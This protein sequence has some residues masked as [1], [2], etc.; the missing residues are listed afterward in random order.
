MLGVKQS[1]IDKAN[2]V[3]LKRLGEGAFQT[4]SKIIGAVVD[5][6]DDTD[7][8]HRKKVKTL[9]AKDIET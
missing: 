2:F 9:K 4:Q 3:V 7:H 1:V 6:Y 8:W 5:G